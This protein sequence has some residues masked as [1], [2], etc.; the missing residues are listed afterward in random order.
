MGRDNNGV[1]LVV[2]SAAMCESFYKRE[3]ESVKGKG[4]ERKRGERE[5]SADCDRERE[6][7]N[8]S[9]ARDHWGIDDPLDDALFLSPLA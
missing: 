9:L 4:R 7:R 1:V 5:G 2:L 6:R 3:R 8:R